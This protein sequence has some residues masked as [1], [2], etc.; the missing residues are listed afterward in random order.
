MTTQDTT[1]GATLKRLLA[2]GYAVTSATHP[3]RVL[4]QFNT[5]RRESI[6]SL[7]SH[8]AAI[9]CYPTKENGYDPGYDAEDDGTKRQVVILEVTAYL[10][11]EPKPAKS[12]LEVLNKR[13]L[14]G[15]PYFTT[16]FGNRGYVL[17]WNGA[18]PIYD[19]QYKTRLCFA[20]DDRVVL[21][22]QAI[23]A[24]YTHG[25]N[26]YGIPMAGLVKPTDTHLVPVDA[27]WKQ[28]HILDVPRH[29]LPELL[30]ADVQDLIEDVEYA[31]WG[32]R[33]AVAKD[34]A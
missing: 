26:Q 11:S 21:L 10:L 4:N 14:L 24:Q 13:G 23:N 8:P 33:P 30:A 2:L 17:Q 6:R 15:G 1:V 18:E 19:E 32:A 3:D 31:R 27:E 20:S 5:F 29:K 9:M 7:G 16:G 22:R 34:A 12:V 28:G 25:R